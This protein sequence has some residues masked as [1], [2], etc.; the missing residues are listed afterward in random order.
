MET[1]AKYIGR[2]TNTTYPASM[3]KY[4][5][6]VILAREG[7]AEFEFIHKSGRGEFCAATSVCDAQKIIDKLHE[8][9][10]SL[11]GKEG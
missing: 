2:A 4:R 11:W 7:Y 10:G 1:T 3:Y 9:D 5:G 6:V 8:D